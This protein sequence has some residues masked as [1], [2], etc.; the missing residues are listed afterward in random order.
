MGA[1]DTGRQ[2]GQQA[3]NA[4]LA[5]AADRARDQRIAREGK[6]GRDLT[7]QVERMRDARIRQQLQMQEALEQT[8]MQT[9]M[10]ANDALGE[11]LNRMRQLDSSGNLSPETLQP[12]VNDLLP[13]ITGSTEA[14]R[15]FDRAVDIYT[16]STGMARNTA[17]KL[18]E[19]VALNEFGKLYPLTPLPVTEAGTLDKPV[20]RE[21]IRAGRD[22]EKGLVSSGEIGTERRQFHR[23]FIDALGDP[24]QRASLPLIYQKIKR[25]EAI[26]EQNGFSNFVKIDSLLQHLS[27]DI[28]KEIFSAPAEGLDRG[29]KIPPS[30]SRDEPVDLTDEFDALLG[31]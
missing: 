11:A 26:S 9:R 29:A 22:K 6:A 5:T 21:M 14:M 23:E 20:I 10:D 15:A 17:Q 28:Q 16:Q 2:L 4:A 7:L 19:S 25:Q 18:N 8:R 13:R 27:P 1:F 31:R 3:V 30:P 12:I 24:L